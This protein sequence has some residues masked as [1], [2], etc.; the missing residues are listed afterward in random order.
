MEKH[1]VL[2]NI[3][4]DGFTGGTGEIINKLPADI[5]YFNH[6][7]AFFIKN[8][9]SISNK[10]IF[11]VGG[12]DTVDG[13]LEKKIRNTCTERKSDSEDTASGKMDAHSH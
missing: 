6:D 7:Q 11:L 2:E 5:P 1:P 13:I 12:L 9:L 3:V 8:R 10:K 4:F